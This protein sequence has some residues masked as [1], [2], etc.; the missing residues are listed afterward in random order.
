MKNKKYKIVVLTDLKDTSGLTLKS[1]VSL[2]KMIDG[3][4]ELFHVKKPT[5]V[6]EIDNQL[7]AIRNINAEHLATESEIKKLITPISKEYGIDINSKFSF[8][9]VKTEL[10]KYIQESQPDII[11]LG[12]RKPKMIKFLGD[13][14]THF[15]LKNYDGPVMIAADENALEPN[16]ELSFG[17]L[18]AVEE[19]FNMDFSDVL[20]SHTQKPLKSFKIIKKSNSSEEVTSVSN[21]D[22][23]EYVFEQGDNA[24][25]NLSKYLSISNINLLFVDRK[26]NTNHPNSNL[27]ESE[28]QTV[29]DNL[30][31]SLL[32]SNGKIGYNNPV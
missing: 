2:A 14:I 19:N 25:N 6:V 4:I 13:G 23:V 1:T 16:M 18:N 20:M 22:M 10:S 30:N 21:K 24:I 9:N 27:I 3:D 26:E 11:V 12:K 31:I 15:V 32:V 29:M 28:I 8:G 17:V 7:S 5:D